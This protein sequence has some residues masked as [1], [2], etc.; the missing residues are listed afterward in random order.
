VRCGGGPFPRDTQRAGTPFPTLQASRAVLAVK[1][2]L[3]RV[4]DA[5][6]TPPDRRSTWVSTATPTMPFRTMTRCNC[7]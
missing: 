7:R 5:P 6:L 3:R 4:F 1:G 2:S